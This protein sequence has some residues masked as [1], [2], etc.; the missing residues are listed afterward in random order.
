MCGTSPVEVVMVEGEEDG[1]GCGRDR[2]LAC[3][4]LQLSRIQ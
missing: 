4:D 3:T 1:D 2:M